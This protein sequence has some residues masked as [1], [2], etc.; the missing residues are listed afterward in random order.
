MQKTI[1]FDIYG[2]LIDTED[3]LTTLQTYLKEQANVVM[4]TWRNKQLEYSFRRG[5][6]NSYVDFSVCTSN[7]LDYACLKHKTPLTADQ[8]K[9]LLEE[10]KKLPVFSDVVTTLQRL[11]QENC[12][13]IAF[14]NGSK[15]ALTELL[16]N[17][18]ILQLFDKVVSV[19]DVQSFK[20]SPVVYAHLL[21]E[22]A[23]KIENTWLI[24][25]NPF[26]ITGASYFGL[27]TIWVQ[28]TDGSIFDPWE[29]QP[30]T[31][32]ANLNDIKFI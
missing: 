5:L 19:E 7:A 17:A 24:S 16:T 8:K 9:T 22:A 14:S 23:S 6:M 32:V 30:T 15:G 29:I 13:L 27:N 18:N 2:T 12:Q 1:A 31:I 20:P 4:E 21:T 25:S 3:V 28:R 26:D 10:Y 11:K